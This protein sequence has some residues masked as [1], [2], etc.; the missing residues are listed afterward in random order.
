MIS[1]HEVPAPDEL[2]GLVK[3]GGTLVV[4][5]GLAHLPELMAGLVKHG[6]DP[7]LPAAVVERVPHSGS[8]SLHPQ[9]APLRVWYPTRE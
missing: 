1:G 8:G 2:E 6:L 7:E 3:V 5:M 4:L 9:R